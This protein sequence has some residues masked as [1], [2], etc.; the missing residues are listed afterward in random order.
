[1]PST[2]VVA[3]QRQHCHGLLTQAAVEASRPRTYCTRY[4]TSETINNISRYP[5]RNASTFLLDHGRTYSNGGDRQDYRTPHRGSR[6]RGSPHELA[7]D[8]DEEYEK[9]S[10][11]FSVVSNRSNL[12]FC[13]AGRPVHPL[14][15][16]PARL[17]QSPF[18]SRCVVLPRWP[19]RR[20][21]RIE[22][23]TWN[24]AMCFGAAVRRP[25]QR[26]PQSAP[27]SRMALDRQVHRT[28]V[29]DGAICGHFGTFWPTFEG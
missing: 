24:R 1:M 28:P 20:P 13:R 2:G 9:D 12:S 25:Y 18:L 22:A 16:S 10:E 14:R 19:A 15:P 3:Q 21:R 27:G 4:T 8:V 5:H 7:A 29:P 17:S 26:P 23:V 6:I 11:I